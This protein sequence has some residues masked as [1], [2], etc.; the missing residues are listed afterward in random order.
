M[1]SRHRPILIFV[2]LLAAVVVL[3]NFDYYSGDYAQQRQRHTRWADCFNQATGSL[4]DNQVGLR[5]FQWSYSR[6]KF[7]DQLGTAADKCQPLLEMNSA[8][9]QGFQNNDET[10]YHLLPIDVSCTTLQMRSNANGSTK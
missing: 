2:I 6:F 9:L 4:D 8:R 3:F 7:W 1:E 5:A 10:K